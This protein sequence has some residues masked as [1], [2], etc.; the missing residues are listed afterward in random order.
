MNYRKASLYV[1]FTVAFVVCAW[2]FYKH[3]VYCEEDI[4]LCTI[5]GST[6]GV[7]RYL[8]FKKSPHL[9]YKFESSLEKNIR[10][11]FPDE[12]T[13]NWVVCGRF[14]QTLSGVRYTEVKTPKYFFPMTLAK[15]DNY[16]ETLPIQEQ[17]K[18][19]DLLRSDDSNAIAIKF[20][21][22]NNLIKQK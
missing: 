14:K 5:T 19:Y 4:Y 18:L 17:K 15:M 12:I 3:A 16:V 8:F 6:K 20:Q 22:I 21:E 2:Q 10:K 13:N 7:E 1:F 11:H 9:D